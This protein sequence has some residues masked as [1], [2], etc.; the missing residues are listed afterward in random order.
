M[1]CIISY[2]FLLKLDTELTANSYYLCLFFVNHLPIVIFLI[3]KNH[4]NPQ[5][6]DLH[7]PIN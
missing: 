5:P 7:Y 6:S 4:D 3:C 1:D 2:M